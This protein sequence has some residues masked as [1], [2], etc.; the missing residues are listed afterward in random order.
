LKSLGEREI[1]KSWGE[2]DR[3]VWGRG[4]LK[5]LGEREIEKSG[6]EGDRKVWGKGRSKSL[7]EREIEK[8]RGK[9]DRKVLGEREIEKSRGEGIKEGSPKDTEQCPLEGLGVVPQPP[10][11][12]E[13]RRPQRLLRQT[14]ASLTAEWL[15]E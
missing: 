11:S 1:E 9:G 13:G 6:G 4:G 7:G 10:F 5:S 14:R 3:K 8:S 15:R 2:G 12:P